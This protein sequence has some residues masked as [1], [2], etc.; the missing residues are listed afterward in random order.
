MN[1]R[2]PLLF[3][4]FFGLIVSNAQNRANIWYFG[5]NAGIDFN[6]GTPTALLD[7]QLFTNE[8]CATISDNGGNLQFYTDGRTVYNRDHAIMQNGTGLHGH[9]T[10]THSAVIVP[11]PNSSTKY[12]IFTVDQAFG[13]NGLQY[14]IVDLSLDGGLGAV[15][16]KNIMLFDHVVEKIGSYKKAN[17]DEFWV[18]AQKYNSNEFMSYEVTAAGISPTPVISAVGAVNG[19]VRRQTGQIKISPD[20]KRLAIANTWE[21]EVFDFDEV[22]GQI[23][24]PITLLRNSGVYGIEFSPDSNLLYAAYTGEVCQLDLN[25]G[26][27][28]DIDNS[29]VVINAVSGESFS[30]LQLGPDNKIYGVKLYKEYLDVIHN[31]NSKGLACDYRYNELYLEGR[32]GR[33]GLPTFISNISLLEGDFTFENTCFGDAT[34]FNRTST[35]PV[36]TIEWDFGDGNISNLDNPSHTYA[37]PGTYQVT[38]TVTNGT[39]TRSETQELTINEIPMANA[40]P[41]IEVCND[42]A[43]YDFDLSTLDASV[44]GSQDPSQFAVAYFASQ[45]DADNNANPL[46]VNHTFSLGITDVFVRISNNDNGQCY[47]TIHF[48]VIVKRAP[49]LFTPTDWTVCDDDGDGQYTFDLSTKDIEILNG[50][51][52]AEFQVSYFASQADADNNVNL[53][54]TNHTNTLAQETIHFRIQ[55]SAYP[56]CYDTGAFTLDVIEQV[57][58]HQ[59]TDLEVCDDDNDGRA[60]FDLT[61]AEAEII[62]AQNPSGLVVSYHGS[63]ADADTNSNPLPATNYES[64][65]YQNTLY[66]RV[67]NASDPSCYAT[68]SFG[69]LIYDMP[70]AP[71]VTD[72]QVCD[73]DNDGL[74]FFDLR[75]KNAEI[76][77]GS[78]EL[79]LTYHEAQADAEADQNAIMGTFQN[80]GNPQ[81][82][83][84]RLE[85]Q[86]NAQCYAVGSFALQVFDTPT[87]YQPA[88][89]V[90]CDVDETGSYT[91]DLS[92]KDGEVLNTQ[93]P[94]LYEVSY[95]PTEL[96]AM[97]ND[98]AFSKTAYVNS[99][100]NETIFVRVQ[101]G[102]LADCY[103]V[104]Q[105]SIVVNPL[106]QLPLEESYVICPDSPDLVIDG[107]LFE[108]YQWRNEMGSIIG[109]QQTLPINALGTYSLTVTQTANG[110]VCENSA[111]FEVVSSGA[112]ESF[113]VS[114]DGFS[115]TVTLTID[116]VGIGD[117]EYSI[118]GIDYRT[119]N[120]FEV[121]PGEY[122]VYVRDPFECRVLTQEVVAMGYQ[123][124]FTPNGDGVNEYWNIIGASLF[125]ESMLYIYDRYGKMM[126]QI[127]P[128]GLGWDGNYQGQPMPAADY[129]FRYDYGIGKV[130]TGHFTLKR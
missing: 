41:D 63:Q 68:T 93:D 101:H 10:A 6:S 124:F 85:N 108:T 67:S 98:N 15:T 29:K 56:E 50:Q 11:M 111:S 30:S 76:L 17:S 27:E 87:A 60:Y 47:D 125:P 36:S 86:N 119:N 21:A 84:F 48:E 103:D 104:A 116:A 71:T 5:E 62:G 7:G 32:R 74:Y 66:V 52:P 112:P 127:S 33:L 78:T 59:P 97:N 46:V 18:V 91:F 72:W 96:D 130:F 44:L 20:G 45:A 69:L 118:D 70:V 49:V 61:M 128:Q 3:L 92:Q 53:L 14:S 35:E 122:T 9:D 64:I 12:Y 80:T 120:R 81:T 58:A 40:L 55:N 22:T 77:A 105:F 57:L 73:D 51:A 102:E 89:V 99:S 117:F 106:P 114:T 42:A 25:A 31:P 126:G 129:W 88:N 4:I 83:Y 1:S 113:T 23:S 54:P 109:T 39:N 95:H 90:V 65:G 43:N 75:E 2:L 34:V 107:G 79:V 24:N 38:L 28:S 16:A 115:D 110:L 94:A 123:R 19:P 82:I 100:L 26:S 13:P 8:G 37:A 121:F